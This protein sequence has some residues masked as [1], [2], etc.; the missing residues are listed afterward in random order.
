[1]ENYETVIKLQEEKRKLMEITRTLSLIEKTYF[2]GVVGDG[3]SHYVKILEGEIAKENH[4][5]L[6][7]R[8][9]IN[10][11]ELEV[12]GAAVVA[13]NNCNVIVEKCEEDCYKLEDEDLMII[14]HQFN[15]LSEE[16][17][18]KKEKLEEIAVHDSQI[19]ALAKEIKNVCILSTNNKTLFK[20][21]TKLY[22]LSTQCTDTFE[23]EVRLT[24]IDLFNSVIECVSVGCNK[25]IVVF[26]DDNYNRLRLKVALHDR[27]NFSCKV[28]YNVEVIANSF[29]VA[30]INR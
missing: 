18:K 1:M 19:A 29:V 12:K 20:G 26:N 5:L 15:K 13:D 25:Y 6:K 30:E 14:K 22:D 9:I 10:K 17:E 8:K 21:V 24:L 7:I 23:E 3:N 16:F 4:E 27:T 2:E 28:K 11:L